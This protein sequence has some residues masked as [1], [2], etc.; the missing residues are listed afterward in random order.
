MGQRRAGLAGTGSRRRTRRADAGAGGPM[1]VDQSTFR[2][3]LL[4]AEAT[5]PDGL[6]DGAGAPAGRRFDVYRNNVAVS[7]AD[8]L[9]AAFPVIAKL[10]GTRN[11]RLLAGAFLRSHPPQSPLM[12]FYGA[13]MP[14]FL[15]TFG[16]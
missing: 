1:I 12:M 2:A 15:S 6:T 4:D 5:R 16:P 11:F 7:L 14:T 9:E 10:V 8:A 13:E 3:A